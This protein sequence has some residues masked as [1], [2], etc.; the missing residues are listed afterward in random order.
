MATSST[1]QSLDIPNW[2]MTMETGV[3]GEWLISI[4]DSFKQGDPLVT[5]ESTKIVNDLEAP[6]DGT[7]RRLVAEV[8]EDLPVG[9][10][11]AVSADPSASDEDIA[12]F[13]EK[14]Q[15][16]DAAKAGSSAPEPPAAP[17]PVEQPAQ[18]P[19]PAVAAAV[20]PEVAPTPAGT[21]QTYAIPGSLSGSTDEE[22]V[23]ATSH[24]LRLARKYSID[25]SKITGTGRYDRVTVDDIDGAVRAAGGTVPAPQGHRHGGSLKSTGDDSTVPATPVARRVAAELGVNLLDARPTGRHGRVTKADVE[26]TARRF[27]IQTQADAAGTTVDAVAEPEFTAVPLSAVRKVIGQRLQ[28]SKQNAPHYR[29]AIDVNVNSIL[30]LRVSLNEKVPGVHL[31]I[32]DLIIKAVAAA[33]VEVPEVN[34]NYDEINNAILNFRHAD[35]SV[36][37]ATPGGLITPIIRQADTKSLSTISAE[38][39]ELATR[40][41]ANTLK[42]DEFQGGTFTISNLG[43]FGITSFDAII[44]P[45]QA[46]ILAVGAAQ[47]RPALGADGQL[48]ENNIVTLTLSSDHRVIDGALAARFL[49]ALARLLESPELLLV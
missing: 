12:A 14:R 28:A 20:I 23:P 26:D 43:M 18:Q 10:I 38:A 40:A 33:L 30:A 41:K 1:I 8:G 15:A 49:A 32:N 19:A 47:K 35:I 46:A 25:L 16:E 13:V 42:P 44:N 2:G 24:A 6:F 48:T 5:I 27:D 22:G 7:L 31:S 29:V 9:A 11:I 21:A 37:V 36:A 3:V 4:G 34:V 39:R 45:P 17:Q